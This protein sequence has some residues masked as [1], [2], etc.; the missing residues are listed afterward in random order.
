MEN[1]INFL[2]AVSKVNY[3][4]SFSDFSEQLY[5]DSVDYVKEKWEMFRKK[6]FQWFT[7]LNLEKQMK[8]IALVNQSE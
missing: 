1:E 3:N 2:K 8:Y 5:P 7:S 6:F 4:M